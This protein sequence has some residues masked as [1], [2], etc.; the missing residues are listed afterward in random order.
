MQLDAITLGQG[1]GKKGKGKGKTKKGTEQKEGKGSAVCLYCGKPNH[2][3]KDCR[4]YIKDK[5]EN[6]LQPDK[7]GKFAGKAAGSGKDGKDPLGTG[8]LNALTAD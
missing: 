7:A 6:K 3:K 8:E 1:K 2:V 5:K 4:H